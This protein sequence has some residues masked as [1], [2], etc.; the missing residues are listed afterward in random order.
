MKIEKTPKQTPESAP[1]GGSAPSFR[2]SA[3]G[4]LERVVWEHLAPRLIHP[5]KLA[6][7][8]GLLEAGEPL[9]LRELADVTKTTKDDA[10]A[11]CKEM[12]TAGVLEVV[13]AVGREDDEGEEPFYFFAKAAEPATGI[14]ADLGGDS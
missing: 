9:S 4:G 8:Q 2:P 6:F 3:A 5:T 13:R 7:I 11:H 14:P 1:L 10:Q 12:Q